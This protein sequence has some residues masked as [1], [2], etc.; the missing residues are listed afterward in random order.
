VT[1]KGDVNKMMN[2]MEGWKENNMKME[3][4]RRAKE[5]ESDKLVLK[6]PVH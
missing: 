6:S 4:C 3:R 5:I 2:Y 1:R